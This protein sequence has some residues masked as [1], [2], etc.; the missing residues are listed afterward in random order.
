MAADLMRYEILLQRG[1]IYIDFKWQGNR[2]LDNFLKYE[3]FFIDFDIED[4]RFGRPKALGN[5]FMGAIP[6]N[7]HLKMVLTELLN[8]NTLHF[9]PT[10]SYITGGWIVRNAI[11]DY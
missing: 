6:N 5:G 3:S 1:G 7:Y 11:S 4:I 2:P 9:A 8:E 10:I